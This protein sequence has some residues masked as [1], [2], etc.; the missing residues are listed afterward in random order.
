VRF[1]DIILY[2]VVIT[3]VSTNAYAAPTMTINA[4]DTAWMLV[5]TALVMI[6][7]PG[8]AFFYSG[9][10]HST[11]VVATMMHSYMKLCVV[12]LV[13]LLCAYSFAFA[14]SVRG[15]IGGIDFLAFQ[16]VDQN[17][18]MI[19]PTIPHLLFAVYQGMFAVITAA[20]ITGAFAERVRLGAVLLFSMIWIIIV[21]A[22]IAHWIWGGG[23]IATKI[24]SLDFAGGAV[25]HISSGVAGLVAALWIGKRGSLENGEQSR[26][27]NLPLTILGAA[28][29]WFGWFGFNAGS[30]LS[31]SGL[32]ASAFAN[33]NIAAASAAI[34]WFIIEYFHKDHSTS[35]GIISG[36][37]AGLVAITPA[38]GYVT[39]LS[40][41]IIGMGG[42]I[43]CYIAVSIVKPR[44]GYDDSL[45]AF[46]IHGV[47]GIWGAL[48]TGLFATRTINS[49]GN[50][51][52]FYGNPSLLWA[53]FITIIAV[54]TY[55]AIMT[56]VILFVIQCIIRIRVSIEEEA[57]GLDATQHGEVGYNLEL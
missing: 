12:S 18:A 51:G 23:W 26:P 43:V 47:G 31:A 37:V 5:S 50:D 1:L 44:L 41:V 14:P 11:N 48:A 16:H 39:P 46:G 27:H 8:L 35:L 9:M 7:T 21:Y 55:T 45:D 49:A 22:P 17:P 57:K 36:S 24:K 29:L 40:A 2:S 13:W 20:I 25:V 52:V 19:A 56:T 4:G 30:A 54:I 32:A 34:I 15:I 53:Q 10:V 28:L 42:G 38:A 6:M 3:I 33:T